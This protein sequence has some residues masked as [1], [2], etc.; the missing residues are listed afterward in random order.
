MFDI[1]IR[2][3]QPEDLESLVGFNQALAR[4]TEDMALNEDTL[5]DGVRAI[6]HDDRLGFYLVA[7]ANERVVGSLM[8]TKEWSDWRN[9]VFWW[10]QSVYVEADHRRHGVFR[11]LYHRVE[12]L[13]RDHNVC[14]FRLYVEKDNAAA[15]S[16]YASL[17]MCET[18]YKM[19]EVERP[20]DRAG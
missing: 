12:Q 20:G 4:E 6:L 1:E 11:A 14:G 17:G 13:A 18:P 5:R 8:I 9:G 16:T 15:Q 19:F 3:A 2:S 7:V 10:I